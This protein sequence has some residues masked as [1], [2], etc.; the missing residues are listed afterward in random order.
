RSIHRGS[1][2]VPRARDPTPAA[3]RSAPSRSHRA[4]PRRVPRSTDVPPRACHISGTYRPNLDSEPCTTGKRSC[5]STIPGLKNKLAENLYLIHLH[6]HLPAM[7]AQDPAATAATLAAAGP[8]AL[9]SNDAASAAADATG[10]V[11]VLPRLLGRYALLRLM[12]RGGMG[13]VFLA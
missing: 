2:P 1:A 10:D 5:P 11:E 7:T 3:A 9:P 4:S 13:E 8:K 6:R 12:V